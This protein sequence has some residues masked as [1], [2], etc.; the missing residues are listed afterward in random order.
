[1]VALDLERKIARTT[2]REIR[3]DNLVSSIPFPALAQAANK[4]ADPSLWTWNK[5]L[6]F[7]L[8]F[9]AKGPERV[10]W[11]YYPDRSLAFYRVGFYDN[12]F[13]TERMSLYVEIGYPADA[14][15]D[16][17]AMLARTLS[18]LERVGVVRD[19]RLVSHHS[20]VLDPAYVHITEASVRAHATLKQELARARRPHH[21]TVRWLDLLL[22]RRQRAGGTSARCRAVNGHAPLSC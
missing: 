16:V 5:V 22:H 12:I 6:V 13:D 18:D 4:L 19:Q 1:M 17:Q 2:K 9:D 21:R 11:V 8:G 20:V 3:F 15:V 7:N 14:P 10:H